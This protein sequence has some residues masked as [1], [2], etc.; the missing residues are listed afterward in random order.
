MTYGPV[1][2]GAFLQELGVDA[3]M[4]TLLRACGED[5]QRARDLISAYERLIDDRHM[6]LTY[7]AFSICS[8]SW[9]SSHN[10]PLG[11]LS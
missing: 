8:S 11:F 5:E 3:R 4:A 6:G 1:G 9:N 7:K 2:Q 10:K